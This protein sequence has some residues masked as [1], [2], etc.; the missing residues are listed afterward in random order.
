MPLHLVGDANLCLV[1]VNSDSC[2]KRREISITHMSSWEHQGPKRL[3]EF[4]S[5]STAPVLWQW[6]GAI[7]VVSWGPTQPRAPGPGRQA[8]LQAEGTAMDLCSWQSCVILGR[9]LNLSE[10]RFP[11]LQNRRNKTPS[12]PPSGPVVKTLHSNTGDVG[13]VSGWGN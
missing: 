10:P 11:S 5:L 13:S 4:T 12:G 8:A 6:V 3:G 9:T 2:Y 1:M 7:W